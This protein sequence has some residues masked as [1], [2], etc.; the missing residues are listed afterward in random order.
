M[1]DKNKTKQ[2]LLSEIEKLR[3]LLVKP[4]NS[5]NTTG[6]AKFIHKSKMLFTVMLV[7]FIK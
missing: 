5:E 7:V 1:N 2:Q 4:E 3:R 6:R